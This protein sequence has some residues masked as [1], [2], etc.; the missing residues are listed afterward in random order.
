ML[1][2]QKIYGKIAS[3]SE[4]GWSTLIPEAKVSSVSQEHGVIQMNVSK[5]DHFQIGDILVIIPIHSCLTANLFNR[6]YL[7][8]G[9]SINNIHS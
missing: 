5:M 9:T 3:L 1:P 6:Y 2:N 7:L 4:S 8:D